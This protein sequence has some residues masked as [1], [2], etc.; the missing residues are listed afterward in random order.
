MRGPRKTERRMKGRADKTDEDPGK[1]DGE[2]TKGGGDEEARERQMKRRADKGEGRGEKGI[3]RDGGGT[4]R[5]T[6][7]DRRRN[8]G[9]KSEAEVRRDKEREE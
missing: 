1:K 7:R 3:R 8:R 6:A 5:Q 9:T 4:R 2:N